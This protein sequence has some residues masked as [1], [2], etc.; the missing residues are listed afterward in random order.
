MIRY[1]N[2][3]HHQCSLM[4]VWKSTTF[5]LLHTMPI[6][7]SLHRNIINFLFHIFLSFPLFFLMFFASWKKKPNPENMN[8]ERSGRKSFISRVCWLMLMKN[9]VCHNW[10]QKKNQRKRVQGCW[11]IW[12]IENWICNVNFASALRQLNW[13]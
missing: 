13:C 5:F 9:N 6:S 10:L 12:K 1:K 7:Y 4:I 11:W 8:S 2:K 3:Q